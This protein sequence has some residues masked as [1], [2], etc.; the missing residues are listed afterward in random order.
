MPLETEYADDCD[1]YN[2]DEKSLKYMFPII[3]NVF[4]DWN[5]VVNQK[6]TEYTNFF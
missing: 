2:E 5:L 4:S 6:K 3:E 1:F